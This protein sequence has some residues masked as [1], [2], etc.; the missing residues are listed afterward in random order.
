[1]LTDI[2]WVAVVPA[3]ILSFAAAAAYVP[4]AR[5]ALDER[6]PERA[7]HEAAAP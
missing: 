4:F 5:R 3:L 7:Q 1:V 6:R 2:T